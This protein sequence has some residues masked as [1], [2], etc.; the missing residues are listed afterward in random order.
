MFCGSLWQI[1]YN[2]LRETVD[3]IKKILNI[4]LLVNHPNLFLLSF[5][6]APIK[7]SK[8]KLE[9]LLRTQSLN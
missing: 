7:L 1:N 8:T 4:C 9:C 3:E 2:V 5:F 6:S